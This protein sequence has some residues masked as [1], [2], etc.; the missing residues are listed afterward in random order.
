MT[1]GAL[2]CEGLSAGY[3][4]VRVGHDLELTV[5]PGEVVALFGPNGAGNTTSLSH[6]RGSFAPRRARSGSTGARYAG[7]ARIWLR[8][9]AS[10][11]SPTTARSSTACRPGR[12]C[13]LRWQSPAR[14][15]AG[16][17]PGA[18]VPPR[19]GRAAGRRR[20]SCPGA[21]SRCSRSAVRRDAAC[22]VLMV[23]EMS[24][25]PRAARRPAASARCPAHRRRPLGTA[26][27]L[28]L[29]QHVDLALE[30]ADRAYASSPRARRD[31][32]PREGALAA[33]AT[34]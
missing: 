12:T 8:A 34:S 2:E 7:D 28:V 9:P 11:L 13:A 32:G 27:L 25:G 4:R 30:I 26:V 16:G 24:L 5:E 1:S 14:S 31:L 18:R 19:S 22:P 20:G 17:A 21:S 3:S 6:C 29:E 33:G 23:D 10:R 15:R